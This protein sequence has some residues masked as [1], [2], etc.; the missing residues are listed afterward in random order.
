[1]T[2][3]A[4]MKSLDFTAIS[5]SPRQRASYNVTEQYY[6]GKCFPCVQQ[7]HCTSTGCPLGPDLFCYSV[8]QHCTSTGCP[9]GPDL[10]CYSV[11]QHCTSTGCPLGPDLFCYSVSQHCTSTGCPLGPD[12]FCY[13]VSHK[14]M[15]LLTD[16]TPLSLSV[17][18]VYNCVFKNVSLLLF[19]K[20]M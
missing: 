2:S 16:V 5:C 12:L 7:K 8:S 3:A 20:N 11:S 6:S 13:S 17:I 19:Q 15:C 1:M 4:H 14:V 18:S 9:L 10:F